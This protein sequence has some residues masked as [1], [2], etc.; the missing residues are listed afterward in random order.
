GLRCCSPSPGGSPLSERCGGPWEEYASFPRTQD[1]PMNPLRPVISLALVGLLAGACGG[2]TGSP[3][4]GTVGGPD[5]SDAPSAS[6]SAPPGFVFSHPSRTNEPSSLPSARAGSPAPSR[7]G[8]SRKGHA[9]GLPKNQ[10]PVTASVAPKC[11][12]PGGVVRLAVK[13]EP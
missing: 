3:G 13:T 4:P 2:Q 7:P 9:G 11:V 5:G 10:V 1:V 8:N 6:P 12:G